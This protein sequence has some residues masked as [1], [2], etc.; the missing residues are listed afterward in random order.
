MFST[1]SKAQIKHI[2]FLHQKKFRQIYHQFIVEGTKSV[3]EFLQSEFNCIGLYANEENCTKFSAFVPNSIVFQTKDKELE[4]ITAFKTHQGVLAVFEIKETSKIDT[5]ANVILA[6]D[7]IRDPGNLGTIIRLCDWF[8]LNQL[9][10]S[11]SS[12]D[13]YNPKV[14]QAS[15]GSLGRINVV[16]T[17][18][19]D[20]LNQ[21]TDYN[22]L[23]ADMNGLPIREVNFDKSIIVIGNEANGL[24]DYIKDLKHQKITIPRKGKAESLNAAISAGIILAQL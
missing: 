5:K 19:N 24:S 11:P 18:L 23:L 22:L 8:G 4:Q 14:V 16:Y 1:I 3:L 9:I 20:F 7:D 2:R 6:L 15:M 13:A 21:N 12:A 17:D 10:C